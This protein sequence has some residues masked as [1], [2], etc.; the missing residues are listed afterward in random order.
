MDNITLS[1]GG[2]SVEWN[3]LPENS[4]QALAILG[5]ST[6]LKNSV[7][8]VKKAVMGEGPN[9]WSDE[10]LKEEAESLGLSTYGRN[11]ETAAAIV[12]AIQKAAFDAILS[13]ETRAPKGRAPRQNEAEKALF[14]VKSELFLAAIKKAEK[15]GKTIELPKRSTPEG[16]KEYIALVER[17]Y[18]EKPKFAAAV[19]KEFAARQ[20]KAD[21]IGDLLD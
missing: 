3:A 2:F 14:A 17:T 9:P 5:F 20:K 16:K 11:E 19:D 8:G 4:Q 15:D 7:A 10:D 18:A 13:G 1:F 6:K 12:A 21:A